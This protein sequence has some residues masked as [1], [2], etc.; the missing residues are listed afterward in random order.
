M[1]NI[2]LSKIKISSKDPLKMKPRDVNAELDLVE[3][4]YDALLGEIYLEGGKKYQYITLLRVRNGELG[5]D[6]T[7][8]DLFKPMNERERVLNALHE[9]WADLATAIKWKTEAYGSKQRL[10]TIYP[11]DSVITRKIRFAG[12]PPKIR[13]DETLRE[14]RKQNPAKRVSKS[15]K[16]KVRVMF[17]DSGNG[18]TRAEYKGDTVFLKGEA[19]EALDVRRG[20][21]FTVY[22]EDIIDRLSSKW[23][24]AYKS[25]F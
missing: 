21:N 14:Y 3:A 25:Y 7:P 19:D 15:G 17:L 18:Y 5:M 12:A 2:D 20:E 1:S 16:T 9:R 24:K 22:R 13:F 10:E 8:A 6:L 11:V 23:D 4:L